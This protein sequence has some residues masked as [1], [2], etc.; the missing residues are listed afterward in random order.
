MNY[1]NIYI[2]IRKYN[3]NIYLTGRRGLEHIVR[4][5]HLGAQNYTR[6][7]ILTIIGNGQ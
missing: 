6:T 2:I 7:A 1:I 5:V 3:G 4:V